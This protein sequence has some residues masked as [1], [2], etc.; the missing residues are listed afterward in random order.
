MNSLMTEQGEWLKAMHSLR[1]QLLDVLT[2]AD[3][4]F[5][6]PGNPTLGETFREQAEVERS[7]ADS[8]KTFKQTFD[9][10][11]SD[12]ALATDLA[13]LKDYFK[14]VDADLISNID[15]LSEDDIK[16]NIERN[17][18]LDAKTQVAVYTQA[19]LIFFGKI[20]I[21][22]RAMPKPLPENWKAWI[23]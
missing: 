2:D 3:L 1:T 20:T 9:V 14:S 6:L 19:V 10:G 12:P 21:Y 15:A 23:G 22:Y 17:F 16:K 18:P 11:T 5:S 4:R 8:F 7:Y 13:K